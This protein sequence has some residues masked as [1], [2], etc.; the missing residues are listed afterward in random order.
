MARLLPGRARRTLVGLTALGG[1]L[2]TTAASCSTADAS[3]NP[4]STTCHNGTATRTVTI[5]PTGTSTRSPRTTTTK[6]PG[7][8]STTTTSR[9]RS[10]STRTTTTRGGGYDNGYDDGY[11][12][13]YDH[14]Y[15]NGHDGDHHSGHGS[16]KDMHDDDD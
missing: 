11:R 9:R 14:G 4:S 6:V 15:D 10:T 16:H 2:F 3:T 8:C 5:Y 12:N 1:L 7:G 13:G